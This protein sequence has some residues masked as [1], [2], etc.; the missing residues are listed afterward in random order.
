VD[1]EKNQ[2]DQ[3]DDFRWLKAEPSP[4]WSVL[5][6]NERLPEDIW[7]NTVPGGPG[8][9]VNDILKKVGVGTL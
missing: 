9:G 6:A 7:K 1:L 3:V 2:W 4:N 5:P 8:V